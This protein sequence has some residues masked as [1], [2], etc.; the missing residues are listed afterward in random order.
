MKRKSRV[1]LFICILLVLSAVLSSCSKEQK[2]RKLYQN[3]E[4]AQAAELFE[5]I[6][7]DDMYLM[8]IYEIGHEYVKNHDYEQAVPY[9]E[10]IKALG[11]DKMGNFLSDYLE[12]LDVIEQGDDEKAA[13]LLEPF[14]KLLSPFADT[15]ELYQ[16]VQ[17][18]LEATAEDN[19]AAGTQEGNQ[20]LAEYLESIGYDGDYMP[21]EEKTLAGNIVSLLSQD[22]FRGDQKKA[23]EL[24]GENRCY[25][26]IVAGLNYLLN[27]DDNFVNDSN[28][29]HYEDLPEYGADE[30]ALD[31]ETLFWGIIAL[32]DSDFPDEY[33]HIPTA[34]GE[35]MIAADSEEKDKVYDYVSLTGYDSDSAE[36]MATL[37][38]DL[39][40]P[41]TLGYA[42][43]HSD[44]SGALFWTMRESASALRSGPKRIFSPA[45]Y[46]TLLGDSFVP[47]NPI[48]GGYI[49]IVDFSAMSADV[50]EL[51]LQSSLDN[52]EIYQLSSDSLF[53]ATDPNY[54]R[55][56]IYETITVNHAGT[57]EGMD[58]NK[59][60][61]VYLP[62]WTIEIV[63]L[64]TGE[65]VMTD[66]QSVSAKQTY[67][68]VPGNIYVPFNEL[69]RDRYVNSMES[70]QPLE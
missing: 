30:Y 58:F 34:L 56:A 20:R 63:D 40:E 46:T 10:Q 33:D 19:K 14:N 61:D 55:F 44:I 64:T 24:I 42:V 54:A 4:Y 1:V 67:S 45:E 3:G 60:Y 29:I 23:A 51:A 65:T 8:C 39:F 62:V 7:E 66:T 48:D 50:R 13:E 38:P 22:F 5:E 36:L 31:L 41:T 70:V 49:R 28:F 9:F 68:A 43:V 52:P 59:Q 57:Y 11:N 32:P 37:Y 18:R 53:S 16:G 2:A 47:S 21:L 17:E 27:N 6:D 25:E 26:V 69:N 12:I 35:A 15:R